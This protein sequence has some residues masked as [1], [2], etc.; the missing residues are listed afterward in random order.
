MI[1]SLWWFMPLLGWIVAL[2]LLVVF[3]FFLGMQEKRL[4]K[5]FA[6]REEQIRA[7]K[8]YG[9]RRGKTGK[10][11]KPIEEQEPKAQS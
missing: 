8:V 10:R 11:K 4:T 2:A 3:C 7:A 1:D 5:R 6:E 9:L